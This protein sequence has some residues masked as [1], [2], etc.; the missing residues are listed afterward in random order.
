M[1]PSRLAILLADSILLGGAAQSAQHCQ[2]AFE[3]Q[4]VRFSRVKDNQRT[5]TATLSV[6]S[7]VCS[8][9]SGPV[10]IG[11]LRHKENAMDMFFTE[12]FTW[13]PQQMEISGRMR[14]PVT[15]GFT[16]F[17]T[18]RAPP[19]SRASKAVGRLQMDRHHPRYSSA[20]SPVLI[21]AT[22]TLAGAVPLAFAQTKTTMI[23]IE[24]MDVGSAPA[25]FEFARTGQGGPGRWAVVAD[26]SAGG[27]RAIEQTSTDA[28]SFRFPL[29]IH[30]PVSAKDVEVSI[31]FKPIAGKVD[32]AGGIA[33]RV[34]DADNYVVRANALED[35]VRFYRVVKGKREQL[36]GNDT[37]VASNQ[38]H[39][40]GLKAEGDRFTV[41]FN[42]RELFVATDRTFAA[43][44]RVALWTKA[45]SVTRFDRI[46][47]KTLP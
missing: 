41:T 14:R 39:M 10:H 26:P 27:G 25:E 12:R 24:T 18:A 5:W 47:I 44:G 37:K 33:V 29:A 35:N 6:D 20:L 7:S 21:A 31:R 46:E 8:T 1:R 19:T 9:R 13:K 30:R 22:A 23:P 40:L 16:W 42:G 15:T 17:R 45:D 4:E 43:A 11:F 38:W 36:A 32:Q 28:T 2:P 34:S 3:F